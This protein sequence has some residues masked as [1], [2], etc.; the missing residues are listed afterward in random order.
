METKTTGKPLIG[1][2]RFSPEHVHLTLSSFSPDFR[3]LTLLLEDLAQ[4][5]INLPFLCLDTIQ[6]TKASFTMPRENF[7]QQQSRA[8]KFL[9]QCH[10]DAEI[11]RSTG[12][13]TL[14]PHQSRLK[15]FGLLLE[16]FGVKGLNVYSLCSSLSALVVNTDFDQLNMA[17]KALGKVF[18]L[19]GNHAPFRQQRGGGSEDGVVDRGHRSAPETAAVYWE[20]VIKI[21]GASEKKDLV[22]A[23]AELEKSRL[24]QL[25]VELQAVQQGAGRF[26]MALMQRIDE[27]TYKLLLLYERNMVDSYDALFSRCETIISARE[28]RPAELLYLHGPHFHDR[29]GVAAAALKNLQKKQH[30]LF[31]LG[32]AGTSIYLIT[33]RKKAQLCAAALEKIFIVPTLS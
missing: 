13:L 6:E 1:G 19:P 30:E 18:L 23:T 31:A 10:I 15:I 8:H 11:S 9:R 12:S 27:T 26:E 16:T 24:A 22:M 7:E 28:Q 17:A 32:C 5:K 3:D 21:Y 14:F 2:L 29:Y 33:P 4:D 25:G 20:P